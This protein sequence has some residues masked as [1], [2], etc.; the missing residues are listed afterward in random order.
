VPIEALIPTAAHSRG[1]PAQPSYPTVHLESTTHAT[2]EY[3]TTGTGGRARAQQSSKIKY[4]RNPRIVHEQRRIILRIAHAQVCACS[5]R[6]GPWL[7]MQPKAY[8]MAKLANG[9][10]RNLGIC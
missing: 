9:A 2:C 1:T 7:A 10:V 5:R 4:K 6:D 3:P 8:G